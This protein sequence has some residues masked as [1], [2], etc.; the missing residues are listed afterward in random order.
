MKDILFVIHALGGGG[1]ERVLINIVKALDKTKYNVTLLSIVDSGIYRSQIPDDVNYK[2]IFKLPSLRKGNNDSENRASSGSLLARAGKI[3]RFAASF[4]TLF[5][6]FFPV[7]LLYRIFIKE[8]YDLEIAFLEG[9]STKLVAASPDTGSKKIAWIHVDLS[10]E[11]KS[12][13]FYKSLSD[14]KRAYSKFDSIISVSLGV[15]SSFLRDNPE[16]G[17]RCRVIHNPIDVDEIL[18]DSREDC[19]IDFIRPSEC[20]VFLSVGRVCAQKSFHRIVKA[21]ESLKLK[22]YKAQFLILGEGPDSESLRDDIRKKG[23]E[24]YVS[25][26]GYQ[27]NPYPFFRK[28]DAFLCT[29]VAEG[30]ST[31]ATEAAVLGLPIF[32]TDCAGMAELAEIYEAVTICP[33]STEAVVEMINKAVSNQEYLIN[34]DCPS[35]YFNL[36]NRMDAIEELIDEVLNAE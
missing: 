2:T 34:T 31:T 26:M 23:L 9:P 19:A 25:L 13:R 17:A 36:R 33:N 10:Q 16:F 27:A 6:R 35:D 7:D 29:S 20:P 15:Q 3:K 12:H 18:R 32:T 14:E 4:Y 24:S 30:F 22:G 28:V 11:G 8:N 21:A 5:W 1:A